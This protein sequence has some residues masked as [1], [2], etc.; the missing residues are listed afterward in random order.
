MTT[1]TPI[2]SPRRRGLPLNANPQVWKEYISPQ[3]AVSSA[4]SFTLTHNLDKRPQIV[5]VYALCLSAEAGYSA[6]DKV[7]LGNNRSLSNVDSHYVLVISDTEIFFRFSNAAT[8]IYQAHKTTGNA[9]AFTNANWKVVIQAYA[10]I[11]GDIITS[12]DTMGAVPLETVTVSNSGQLDFTAFDNQKYKSYT[13]ILDYYQPL[14]GSTNM[15]CRVSADGGTTFESSS[16]YA[17]GGES[18]HM[19]ISLSNPSSAGATSG[20]MADNCGSNPAADLMGTIDLFGWTTANSYS[21]IISL[22]TGRDSSGNS[23]REDFTTRILSNTELNGFR[24]FQSSGNIDAKG[25]LYGLQE[26]A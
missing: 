20:L 12:L 18:H 15:Q 23:T 11:T 13:V 6:G 1:P 4:G 19:A 16:I 10:L 22:L 25:T 24:L 17:Y 14:T 21:S 2:M 7:L 5:E 8:P 26:A 9:Q 3:L